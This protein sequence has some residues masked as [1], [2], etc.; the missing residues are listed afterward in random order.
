MRT[1]SANVELFKFRSGKS[2]SW[3]LKLIL[4]PLIF[5]SNV[6]VVKPEVIIMLI[7]SAII[8]GNFSL[9][10]MFVE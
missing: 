6:K 10:D 7:L 2:F 9:L 3:I 8:L 5:F 1:T 4:D